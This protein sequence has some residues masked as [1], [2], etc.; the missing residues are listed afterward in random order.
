MASQTSNSLDRSPTPDQCAAELMDTIHPIMQFIRTEMRSQRQSSLSV[1]QFRVLAFLRRH[2]GA[3]LS[4]VAE[5][6][7]VTRATASTMV[8][9]LVQRGLIDRS[10]DPQERRQVRLQLTPTG[11]EDLERMR[12][13]TRKKIAQLLSHLSSEELNSIS[14]GLTCLNQIFQTLNEPEPNL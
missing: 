9:R 2:A 5:H 12:Q 13:T 7:G 8:D 3:S 6:L 14:Q 11:S 4:D 1:P 10:I